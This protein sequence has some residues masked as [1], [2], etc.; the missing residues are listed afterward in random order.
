MNVKVGELV[1]DDTHI[2]LT[3]KHNAI[4]DATGY[5]SYTLK[6]YRMDALLKVFGLIKV[7]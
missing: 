5:K 3:W 7:I 1:D 2:K 4:S 6:L